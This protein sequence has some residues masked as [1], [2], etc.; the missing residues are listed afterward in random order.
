MPIEDGVLL[1][2]RPTIAEPLIDELRREV[3]PYDHA[4]DLGSA[5]EAAGRLLVLELERDGSL[6]ERCSHGP[7]MVVVDHADPET[8]ANL[9]DDGAADVIT[10]LERRRRT[11]SASAMSSST[12]SV[13]RCSGV[14]GRRR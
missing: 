11:C 4:A 1:V 13:E 9:L 12:W 2:M 6:G 7:V 10:R 8:I 14:A 5:P 3:I